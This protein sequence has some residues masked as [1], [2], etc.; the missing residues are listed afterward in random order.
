MHEVRPFFRT[1]NNQINRVFAVINTG[2]DQGVEK[3]R[4]AYQSLECIPKGIAGQLCKS[5]SV[6]GCRLELFSCR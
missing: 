6:H 3:P 5:E 4:E 2:V 1:Q